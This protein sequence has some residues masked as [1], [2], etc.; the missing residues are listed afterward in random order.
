LGGQKGLKIQ[1]E[2]FKE[3]VFKAFILFVWIMEL[4]SH[5]KAL[6]PNPNCLPLI[7]KGLI[8]HVM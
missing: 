8:E 3:P 1:F 5:E 7:R 4:V 6:P 2:G